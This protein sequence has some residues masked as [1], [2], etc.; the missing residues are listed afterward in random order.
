VAQFENPQAAP[1]LGVGMTP[2]AAQ[3]QHAQVIAEAQR[4]AGV[5]EVVIN[6]RDDKP[7]RY[8]I[9]LHPPDDGLEVIGHLIAAGGEP[10]G[11]LASGV[12]G[13]L[14]DGRTFADLA[15]GGGGGDAAALFADV[16]WSAV[17]RDLA[18]AAQRI[19]LS[20]F[21]AQILHFTHR[22]GQPLRSEVARA[23][24]Y[25]GNY[26]ELFRACAAVLKANNF[27]PF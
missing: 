6:D 27:L 13:K 8:V 20:A 17:G 23:Q 14:I 2:E 16:D 25:R 24:A 19:K 3:S 22:D 21:A 9:T 18:A 1:G 12:V 15:D 7:H 11:R 26:A 10:L 5:V 4:A